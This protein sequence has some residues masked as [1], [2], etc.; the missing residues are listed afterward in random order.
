VIT[1]YL[2]WANLRERQ[3]QKHKEEI[4]DRERGVNRGREEE[5]WTDRERLEIRAAWCSRW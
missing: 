5:K 3:R 1:K 4:R 2:R